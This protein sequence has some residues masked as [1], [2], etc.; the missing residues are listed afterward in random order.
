[1]LTHASTVS[2]ITQSDSA[3]VEMATN[4]TVQKEETYSEAEVIK[5]CVEE[6]GMTI[7]RT[8]EGKIYC[9]NPIT[10]EHAEIAFLEKTT[11]SDLANIECLQIKNSCCNEC[12]KELIKA[13][14]DIKVKP[15]LYFGKLYE[16]K[17]N[18]DFESSKQAIDDLITNKFKVIFWDNFYEELKKRGG[19]LKRAEML[20]EYLEEETLE[21]N[22]AKSQN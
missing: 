14:K 20:K 2:L 18:N 16:D 11:K 19:K 15:K 7:L 22:T 3:L 6:I 8:G 5:M 13:Y 4:L 9:Y 1:M 10:K 21:N 12:S 17:A